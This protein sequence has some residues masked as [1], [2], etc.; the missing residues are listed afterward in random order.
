MATAQTIHSCV[1]IRHILIA[2]DLSHTSDSV[3]GYG[4]DFAHLC[5]AQAEI[6]YVLPPQQYALADPDGMVVCREA[7]RRDLR[8]LQ[9][10]LHHELPDDEESEYKI[11][12]LEGTAA[13]TLLQEAKTGRSDLIVV[14]THGRG[15]LGKVLL[16]SVAAKVFRHSLVPVLTIGPNLHHQRSM[17]E[18]RQIVAPCDLTPRSHPAVHFA[19]ELA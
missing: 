16:G 7:A 12:M 15:G 2:T 14:G 18:I 13:E 6:A 19:C 3:L 5:G 17:R 4:L 8:N 1:G 11:A 10:R 9:A